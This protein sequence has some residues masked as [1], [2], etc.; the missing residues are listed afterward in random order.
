M[1]ENLSDAKSVSPQSYLTHLGEEWSDKL[2]FQQVLEDFFWPNLNETSQV[3]ELGSGGGRVAS[4]VAPRVGAL[5]CYDISKEMLKKAETAVK[6]SLESSDASTPVKFEF[7]QNPRFPGDAS[8]AYDFVYAFDVFPHVDLH[9][10]WNYYKEFSRV[11]KPGAKAIIHTANL[12]APEGWDRFVQQDKYSVGG[13]YFMVP[14]MVLLLIQKAGL[15]VVTTSC[16]VKKKN[17]AH[18][19]Y[20]NRDFLVLVSKPESKT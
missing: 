7:L 19:T 3:A 14:S 2:S 10:Q 15:E 12:E 20:Y 5:H 1:V 11:L 17:G 16:E 18:N 6:Q 13:F 4:R 9:T 8:G